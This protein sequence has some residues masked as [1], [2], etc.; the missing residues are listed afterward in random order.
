MPRLHQLFFED[1]F[2]MT[3]IIIALLC[4]LR[5]CLA[6]I[7]YLLNYNGCYYYL[8]TYLGRYL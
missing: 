8:D 6:R 3:M 2:I 7:V 4:G 5:R 1:A